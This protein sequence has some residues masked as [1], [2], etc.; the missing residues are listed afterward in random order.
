MHLELVELLR[1]P[2]PHA[3]SVLVAASDRTSA[4]YVL[5]GVLG[6]PECGAEYVISGGV[7][8]FD[9]AAERKQKSAPATT[10]LSHNHTE[11]ALRVA[12]QL[13]MTEGRSVYALV[14]FSA[15]TLL[16]VRSLVPARLMAVNPLD[17]EVFGNPSVTLGD[18][19]AGI[20][21]SAQFLP[22]VSGKFDG[23]A[24]A[25]VPEPAMLDQAVALLKSGGRLVAP[26]LSEVPAGVTELVR[27]DRDWVATRDAMA[28]APVGITRR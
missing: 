27:D 14:G 17:M 5:E 23:V 18:A 13:G 19:P 28:S 6:C 3:P 7:A 4:R 20:V 21:E 22:L 10:A 1:C 8:H 16:A 2:R 11:R 12:A 24:F 15:G 25:A 9:V 26:A